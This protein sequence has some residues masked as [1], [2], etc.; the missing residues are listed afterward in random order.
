[1]LY[2]VATPIGNLQDISERALETLRQADLIACED[3][4]HSMKLLSHFDIHT[5]LTSY[6]EHNERGKAEQL[7]RRMLDEGISV[8]L[9]TDAGTPAISDP[10]AI[11]VKA[12][13]EAGIEVLAVPGPNAAAAAMSVSGFLNREHSFFGFPP[14]ENKALREKLLSIRGS[15][16][17]AIFHESPHR[18][19]KLLQAVAELFDDPPVSL[20][21]DLTKLYE[22]TL[23]GSA[24]AVLAAFQANEK[25]RKGEYVLVVDMTEVP[26][27]DMEAPPQ[28]LEARLIE[29]MLMG[30]S[31][32]EAQAALEKAGERRNALYAAALRLKSL[33]SMG[34][35]NL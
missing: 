19:D 2:V 5:P 4:R 21:C 6:H 18:V 23:R 9:I 24:S 14:R 3:T 13:A 16:E 29:R 35:E 20:S 7:V 15:C 27:P 34:M 17:T 11:L 25:A 8:A 32:R 33:F 10:G 31:L 30:D 22:K 1:M 26:A 12:A 28:S